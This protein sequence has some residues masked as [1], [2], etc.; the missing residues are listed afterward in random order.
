MQKKIIISL[1]FLG[2]FVSCT[3]KKSSTG[4]INKFLN[5]ETK[6]INYHKEDLETLGPYKN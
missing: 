5:E 3:F 2:L 4:D 6:M 1:L